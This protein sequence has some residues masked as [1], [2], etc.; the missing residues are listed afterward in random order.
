MKKLSETLLK[1]RIAVR[2]RALGACS[3]SIGGSLVRTRRRCGRPNCRCAQDADARHVS[4]VLTRKVKRKTKVLYVPVGMVKEVE[5]WVRERRRVRRLLAE[6]DALA[7]QLIR[8]HVGA[9]RAVRQ[10]RVRLE[11]TRATSS[12]PA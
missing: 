6:M 9:N 2:C 7:E 5:H 8:N 10:N 11:A 3:A 1:Q 4:H 12:R